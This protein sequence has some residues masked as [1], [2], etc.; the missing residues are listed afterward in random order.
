VGNFLDST[1]QMTHLYMS[2]SIVDTTRDGIIVRNRDFHTS[3]KINVYF[4]NKGDY[5]GIPVTPWLGTFYK[6]DGTKMDLARWKLY[7]QYILRFTTEKLLAEMWF[8]AD[9]S[10]FG[11]LSQVDKNRLFRYAMARTSAFSHMLYVI[12]L[13]WEEG[14]SHSSVTHSGNFIQAHNPWGRPLSVHSVGASWAFSGENWATFVASQPGNDARPHQVNT[15]AVT[16]SMNGRIPHIG[17]EFGHLKADSDARVRANL[18]ANFTGGAAGSGTGS[19][20]RAFLRFL[21][22]SRVPFQRMVPANGLVEG[23]GTTRFVLAETGHHYVVY[24]SGG[25]FKLNLT[26]KDLI[27]RW[28]SPRDPNASLGKALSILPGSHTFAPPDDIASD[29]VLWISNGSNL[30]GG[31]TH[32]SAG[33][34]LTRQIISGISKS[35]TSHR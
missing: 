28:F 30:L 12:A 35:P 21:A 2:E 3:N 32:P 24:S 17:E 26:G 16:L 19:D 34:T 22:K 25:A 18:W 9:D 8:F 6:H 10:G 27:G 11:R 14:W 33:S 23:G 31:V 5:R 15:A 13:E 29:W 4:A 7:D 1:V 20:L